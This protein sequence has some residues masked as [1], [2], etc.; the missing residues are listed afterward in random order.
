MFRPRLGVTMRVFKFVLLA[1][2]FSFSIAAIP[3]QSSPAPAGDTPPRNF[4]SVR[5]EGVDI[6]PVPNAPF[7]A[8]AVLELTQTLPDGSAAT[9]KTFNI[10]ARDS[11]GRTHNE[12]RQWAPQD[13]S[14][15]DSYCN[16]VYDPGTRLRTFLYPGSHS[17]QQSVVDSAP[18]ASTSAVSDPASS[19]TRKVDLGSATQ[20]GVTTQGTRETITHPPSGDGKDPGAVVI[21]ESWY[22]PELQIVLKSTTTDPLYGIETVSVTALERQEPAS[23][24]FDVPK[25]YKLF[26]QSGAEFATAVGGYAPPVRVRIGGNV[27]KGSLVEHPQPKYPVEAKKNDIQGIVRLHAIIGIDGSMKQIEVMSGHPLLVQAAL[28]A[29]R[30]WRYRPITLNGAPVEIDTTIDIFFQIH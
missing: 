21:K 18:A 12:I 2:L 3:R 1:A 20:Q 11:H 26:S 5:V 30:R 6:P 8:R 16:I 19:S 24:L 28:D 7:Y 9:H 22:S 4:N 15:P 25:H 27:A 29:V 10:I 17:G 14:E 13:G 23:S